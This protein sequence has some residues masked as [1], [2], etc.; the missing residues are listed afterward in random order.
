MSNG[1][2]TQVASVSV[3]Y[4]SRLALFT[5]RTSRMGSDG[6]VQQRVCGRLA[7]THFG[8]NDVARAVSLRAVAKARASWNWPRASSVRP[9]RA[10]ARPRL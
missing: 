7:A 5:I 4:F 1:C 6:C 9:R 8:A 10:K 2:C 3:S